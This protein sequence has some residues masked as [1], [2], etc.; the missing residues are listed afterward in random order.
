M[1]AGGLED[2]NFMKETQINNTLDLL[3]NELGFSFKAQEDFHNEF[4]EEYPDDPFSISQSTNQT[5]VFME[6]TVF[7]QNWVRLVRELNDCH[8]QSYRTIK[9][10]VQLFETNDET[11]KFTVDRIKVIQIQLQN[12]KW[13]HL[14]DIE[15]FHLVLHHFGI[16]SIFLETFSLLDGKLHQWQTDALPQRRTEDSIVRKYQDIVQEDFFPEFADLLR[17]LSEAKLLQ[18]LRRELPEKQKAPSVPNYSP[19]VFK[20][21]VCYQLF[22][23]CMEGYQKSDLTKT[24]F[25]KYFEFFKNDDYILE[26]V[27]KKNF[28]HFVNKRFEIKMS[29]LEP[30]TSSDKTEK[31]DYESMKTTF[32]SL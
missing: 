19:L 22:L 20:N 26:N 16:L 14:L 10:Q 15:S 7:L 3:R 12:N 27:K 30:Y 8:S 6:K 29:R 25:S 1:A 5:F 18:I 28:F 21:K 17:I 32:F 24:L 11:A 13:N 9:S 31:G 23:H 2:F 4:L